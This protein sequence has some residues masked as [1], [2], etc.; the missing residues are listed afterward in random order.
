MHACGCTAARSQGDALKRPRLRRGS[1]RLRRRGW[2]ALPRLPPP[3]THPNAAHAAPARLVPP[4]QVNFSPDGKYVLSGDSEGR[5]FFWEWSHPH[6]IIR[7]IK[8]HEGVCIGAVWHPLESSKVIT[9]G[10]DGLV[11]GACGQGRGGREDH[12]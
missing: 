8:A 10:W 6:K 7:T 12:G 11:R 9:C 5:C 4:T 1:G 3:K 2:R